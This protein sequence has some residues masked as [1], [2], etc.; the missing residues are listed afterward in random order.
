MRKERDTVNLMLELA[1]PPLFSA[2][3]SHGRPYLPT[4][5]GRPAR[6]ATSPNYPHQNP[7]PYPPIVLAP[8]SL[9]DGR[10]GQ[11]LNHREPRGQRVARKQGAALSTRV[12]VREQ[13]L[14]LKAA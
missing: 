11:G 6:G 13:E 7:P 12:R 4:G 2:P 5:A 10:K 3:T 9:A 1:V 8:I 14:E